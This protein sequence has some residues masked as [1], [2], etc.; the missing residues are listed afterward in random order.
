MSCVSCKEPQNDLFQI[1]KSTGLNAK[2]PKFPVLCSHWIGNSYKLLD[3]S[4]NNRGS[5]VCCR[6]EV[7]FCFSAPSRGGSSII[8]AGQLQLT[9]GET[10]VNEI[11]CL[12]LAR[13]GRSDRKTQEL[14]R[15]EPNCSKRG[16]W[17]N[18]REIAN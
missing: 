10:T 17:L 5:C 3:F 12:L 2:S 1:A 13:P 11:S 4:Y 14:Q 16:G 6:V 7:S 9:S 8:H 18:F 15:S